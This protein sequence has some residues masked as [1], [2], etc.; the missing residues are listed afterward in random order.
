[1]L[2]LLGLT[3]STACNKHES[4]GL[5][6]LKAGSKKYAALPDTTGELTV[7]FFSDKQNQEIVG[8][9]F[10]TP[11]TRIEKSGAPA[12][13]AGPPGRHQVNGQVRSEKAGRSARF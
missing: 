3:L 13:L 11:E 4:D 1:M 8:S 6:T 12:S 9:A 5:I 7:R 2:A 10:V